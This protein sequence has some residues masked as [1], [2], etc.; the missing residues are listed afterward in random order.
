MQDIE[1]ADP[2]F[3]EHF[4][5]KAND[6]TRVRAMLADPK[7]RDL[8]EQQPDIRFTVKDDEGYF[9]TTFPDGV[10]E[11]S[12]Q[13]CGVI[14]DVERLKLLFDLFAE[15]LDRLCEIGSATPGDPHVTL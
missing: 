15:T 8:I 2:L 4:V 5:V 12:F 7:V 14:K 9:G 13:V 10:D 11:L 6:E 1:I 3:S